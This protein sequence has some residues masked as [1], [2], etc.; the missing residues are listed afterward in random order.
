MP[1]QHVEIAET[2]AALKRTLRREREGTTPAPCRLVGAAEVL[3]NPSCPQAPSDQPI[4]SATNRGN[5][6]KRG[7]SYVHAGVLPYPHGPDGYKQ[8]GGIADTA[9]WG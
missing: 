1:P 9:E 7:A 5:K 6:L 4:Y 8:V 2:I 3:A